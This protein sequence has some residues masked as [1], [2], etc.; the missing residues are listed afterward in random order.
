M[1]VVTEGLIRSLIIY[2]F[3]YV[4]EAVYFINGLPT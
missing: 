4:Y 3:V 1:Q 2:P